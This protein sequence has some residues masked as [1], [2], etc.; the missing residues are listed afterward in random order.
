MILDHVQCAI[1]FS[2]VIILN[3]KISEFD[4]ERFITKIEFRPALW[5]FKSAE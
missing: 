3:L 4:T 5:D 1:S 2:F